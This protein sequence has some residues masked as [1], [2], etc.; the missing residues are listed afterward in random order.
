MDKAGGKARVEISHRA[1]A[2][3]AMGCFPLC[4]WLMFILALDDV[5]AV[6]P[7]QYSSS[8]IV[9]LG[10]QL[11]MH[12]NDYFICVCV[13]VRKACS[14]FSSDHQGPVSNAGAP[15]ITAQSSY[16]PERQ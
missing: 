15:G 4:P 5:T 16:H 3:S 10:T 2:M 7:P 1:K 6:F 8:N 9:S 13:C 11:K 14:G 12:E